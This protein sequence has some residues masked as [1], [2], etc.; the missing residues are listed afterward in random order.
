MEMKDVDQRP[1]KVKAGLNVLEVRVS[2]AHTVIRIRAM[3]SRQVFL[4]VCV[5]NEY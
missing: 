4:V 5:R 2:L 3:L 1:G